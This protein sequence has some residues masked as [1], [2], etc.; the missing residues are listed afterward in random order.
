[1]GRCHRLSS[2]LMPSLLLLTLALATGADAGQD[3]S[4]DRLRRWGFGWDPVASGSGLTV[5]YRFSPVWDLS[6]AAGPNDYRNDLARLNWDD[7]GEVVEDGT[8]QTESNRRE[9]GWVRLVAGRRMWRDGRFGVSGVAAITYRWSVEEFRYREMGS[10]SGSL[11]DYR[12]R[13]DTSD[14]ETWTLALG[15]RPSVAVTSRLH[16]EFEAGLEFERQHTAGES[17]SWWDSYEA[18]DVRTD[19]LETRSFRSYGGFEF[20]QLKFIFWF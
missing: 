9:Q 1:M 14:R 13:R 2:P 7:E 17:V 15:I 8:P 20:Y 11:V 12:N 16:V 10:P 5:R 4:A 18:T 19:N 3:E 6:V